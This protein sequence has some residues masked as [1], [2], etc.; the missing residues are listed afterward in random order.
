M[1]PH[2]FVTPDTGINSWS[3]LSTVFCSGQQW[4][5]LNI[6]VWVVWSVMSC[7]NKQRSSSPNCAADVAV[8]RVNVEQPF[9]GVRLHCSDFSVVYQWAARNCDWKGNAMVPA[10]A[11]T[12]RSWQ[13]AKGKNTLHYISHSDSSATSCPGVVLSFID[14]LT[15]IWR[16]SLYTY[17]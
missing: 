13:S 7:V 12:I 9:L 8:G 1:S 14:L 5:E 3:K 4:T 10:S 17:A 6:S 16:H 11:H 15:M 2:I